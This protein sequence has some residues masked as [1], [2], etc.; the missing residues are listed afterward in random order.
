MKDED[1]RRKRRKKPPPRTAVDRSPLSVDCCD[2]VV[3]LAFRLFPAMDG[4]DLVRVTNAILDLAAEEVCR[5]TAATWDAGCEL[6]RECV[7][8]ARQS[9]RHRAYARL[10]REAGHPH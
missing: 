2:A 5:A 7:R 8:R 9:E 10:D 1:G 4:P 3:E 6:T